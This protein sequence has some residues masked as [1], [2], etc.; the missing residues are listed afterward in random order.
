MQPT[1]CYFC[2]G[3]FPTFFDELAIMLGMSPCIHD[4][5]CIFISNINIR[6]WTCKNH[7]ANRCFHE[8]HPTLASGFEFRVIFHLNWLPSRSQ[9]AKSA[10][11]FH[12]IASW[13]CWEKRLI[14]AF[15]RILI[16][17]EHRLDWNLTKFHFLSL[18]MVITWI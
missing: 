9:R 10:L 18:Q 11:L 13:W 12:Q 1:K 15:Q 2:S 3:S 5:S 7:I 4:N 14:Y 16:L 6:A 17:S 8:S